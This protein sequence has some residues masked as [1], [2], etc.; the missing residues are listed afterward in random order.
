RLAP[1]T[2][3]RL[4]ELSRELSGDGPTA[5]EPMQVAAVLLERAVAQM[6]DHRAK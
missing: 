4:E 6:T 3:G 2:L 1:E 5:I